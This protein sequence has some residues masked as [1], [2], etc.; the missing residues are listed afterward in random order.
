[1][2]VSID[3][4]PYGWEIDGDPATLGRA[5]VGCVTDAMSEHLHWGEPWP[6]CPARP[7]HPML[8]ESATDTWVCEADGV[9][10]PLGELNT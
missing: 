8:F 3:G 9:R 6:P 2:H 10:I 7:T 1:M 4:E 5:V